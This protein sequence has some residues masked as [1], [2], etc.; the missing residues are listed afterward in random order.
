MGVGRCDTFILHI[1]K[2]AVQFS[3]VPRPHP[4]TREKG[5][6]DCILHCFLVLCISMQAKRVMEGQDYAVQLAWTI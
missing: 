2:S 6:G 4:S 5:S 1:T 3:L